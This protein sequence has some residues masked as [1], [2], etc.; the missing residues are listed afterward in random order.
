M[1]GPENPFIDKSYE[2]I[3][4]I[5]HIKCRAK[6]STVGVQAEL[7]TTKELNNVAEH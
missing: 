1:M 5:I 7:A 6:N 2:F 4:S 3:M